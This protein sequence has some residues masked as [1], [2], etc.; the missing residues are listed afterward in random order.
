MTD[1]G[2]KLT[3]PQA[4]VVKW[5]LVIVVIAMMLVWIGLVMLSF[6]YILNEVVPK[7]FPVL[8]VLPFVGVAAFIVVFL[9]RQ[10]AGP[11]ELEA[12]SIKFKGAAGPII[13]WILCF[14]ALVSA[15]H[16]LWLK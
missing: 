11:I 15:V 2:P 14:A 4:T 10:T 6:H 1:I 9:F 13:L 12:F 7:H 3:P 5:V 8:V 16:V